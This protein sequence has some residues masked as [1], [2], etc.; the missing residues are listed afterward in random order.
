MLECQQDEMLLAQS[1][2]CY[3]RMCGTNRDVYCQNQYIATP[4][5]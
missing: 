3:Y 4:L 5:H 2:L 1:Y